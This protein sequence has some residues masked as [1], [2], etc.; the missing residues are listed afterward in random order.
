MGVRQV[1]VRFNPRARMSSSSRNLNDTSLASLRPLQFPIY[2]VQKNIAKLMPDRINDSMVIRN[3]LHEL[4][5]QYTKEVPLNV[6]MLFLSGTSL[7][8]GIVCDAPSWIYMGVPSTVLWWLACYMNS[9]SLKEIDESISEL[10]RLLAK[11]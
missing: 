5:I 3:A 4:K 11:M 8:L 9:V 7:T 10:D 1:R 6:T 2:H